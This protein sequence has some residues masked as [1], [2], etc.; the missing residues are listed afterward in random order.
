M[1][2]GGFAQD[3]NRVF[4][5]SHTSG[6]QPWALAAMMAVIDACERERVAECLL[7]TGGELRQGIEKAVAN[8]GLDS[9]FQLRGRDCNLVYVARDAA[10]QPSQSF[11]TLVLQELLERGILAPSFVVS[12]AHDPASVKQTID[13]VADLM[14]VYRRALEDGVEQVLRGRPVRPA[15]RAR[16]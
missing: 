7:T 11:R 12:A 6:G 2:L 1:R 10:G 3:A 13:A 15:I 16:G 8:A 14:P 4:V 9:Y 5:L